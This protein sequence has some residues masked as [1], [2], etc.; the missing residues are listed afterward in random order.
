MQSQRV[1]EYDLMEA[2][3]HR[4]YSV[5]RR[6]LQAKGNP[7]TQTQYG[8]LLERAVDTKAVGVD[9]TVATLIEFGA[10]VTRGFPLHIAASHQQ[11]DAARMLIKAGADPCKQDTQGVSAIDIASSVNDREMVNMMMFHTDY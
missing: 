10:N 9:E 2:V 7:N 3:R 4:R 5:L 1:T 8:N 6:L 11:L